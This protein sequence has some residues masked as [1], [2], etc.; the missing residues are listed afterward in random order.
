MPVRK[1]IKRLLFRHEFAYRHLDWLMRFYS[2]HVRDTMTDVF[3]LMNF[4]LLRRTAIRLQAEFPTQLTVTP[5][6]YCNAKCV[7]CLYPRIEEEH[8]SMP[9]DQFAA[10]IDEFKANGGS[11][12]LFAPTL[13]EV[14]FDRNFFEKVAHCKGRGLYI[15]VVTNGFQLY[16]P[17]NY[18]SLAQSR[19]DELFVSV[20]DVDPAV[21]ARVFGVS[22]AMSRRKLGGIERLLEAMEKAASPFDLVLL[23][24]PQRRF[25]D[26]LDDMKQTSLWSYYRRNRLKLHW[27][28]SYD[29]WS[30]TIKQHDLSGVQR[31]RSGSKVKRYPCKL[32]SEI[33]LLPTG[34]VRL[35]GC[36]MKSSMHDELVIGKVG[37]SSLLD[38]WQSGERK[39]IVS[40]FG[41]GEFP[42][43]CRDCTLYEPRIGRSNEVSV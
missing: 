5:T 29:A 15:K 43:V 12:I 11:V 23:M 25:R 34:H 18:T 40:A 35:C 33:S 3:S 26:I 4:H 27:I 1:T 7:F 21:D 24:R 14:L 8:T 28:H 30:G 31:L 6:N 22:E 17:K 39:E 19:V 20:G 9:F 32:L 37:E 38:M 42:D 16:I 10:A 36:R 41:R 2:V 13:G